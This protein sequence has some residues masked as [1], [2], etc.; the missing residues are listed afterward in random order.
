M[1]T[2]QGIQSLAVQQRR[3]AFEKDYWRITRHK[4]RA[5]PS[6]SGASSRLI[7]MNDKTQEPRIRSR[8]HHLKASIEMN[9]DR[10]QTFTRNAKA[11]AVAKG[12]VAE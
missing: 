7:L 12:D 5:T 3:F 1:F 8:R 9:L 2:R 6:G 10:G 11:L 4:S